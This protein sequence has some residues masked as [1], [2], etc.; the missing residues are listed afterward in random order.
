MMLFI[1]IFSGSTIWYWIL[2][3]EKKSILRV[4]EP[5]PDGNIH[6]IFLHPRSRDHCGEG[7]ERMEGHRIREFTVRMCL[8]IV[9]EVLLTWLPKHEVKKYVTNRHAKVNGEGNRKAS[10]LH[11][12]LHVPEECSEWKKLSSLRILFPSIGNAFKTSSEVSQVTLRL[13]PCNP[14]K[15]K[16]V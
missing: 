15:W 16:L 3:T 1:C 8:L 12:E 7:T 6:K 9:S 11:T 10:T 13:H 2:N 14:S 4:V 5:S